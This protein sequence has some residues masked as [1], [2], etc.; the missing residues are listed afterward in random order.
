MS[1]ECVSDIGTSRGSRFSMSLHHGSLCDNPHAAT[2]LL[3][4]GLPEGYAL[5][6]E[7]LTSSFEDARGP[8]GVQRQLRRSK[9]IAIP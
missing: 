6:A 2:I 8:S 7:L 4:L 9:I 3:C 1:G 5:V